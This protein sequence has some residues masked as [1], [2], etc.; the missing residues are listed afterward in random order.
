MNTQ[1]HIGI[2]LTIYVLFKQVCQIFYIGLRL[3]LAGFRGLK[4]TCLAGLEHVRIAEPSVHQLRTKLGHLS[5]IIGIGG[6]VC[7]EMPKRR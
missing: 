6:P 3:M 1:N 7:F 4:F 5:L 2:K